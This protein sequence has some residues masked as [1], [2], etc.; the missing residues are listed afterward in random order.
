[1]PDFSLEIQHGGVVVGVDE[2]GR[3]PLAG[4]VYACAVY[5][6][7]ENFSEIGINDSKKM[8]QKKRESICENLLN[9]PHVFWALGQAGV[10]EI[11]TYNI[12]QATFMAMQRAVSEL[13]VS[14]DLVLVDGNCAPN[15]SHKTITVI[16]GDNISTSI[17]AAS[18]IAKVHRDKLM[19]DLALEYPH[20]GWEQNSGYGTKKHKDAISTYGISPMHRKTWC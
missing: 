8:T 3:G 10:D 4:P 6:E 5:I 17:A 11:D 18:I 14:P 12:R 15:W 1:M 16:K 13:Q 20:Y 19:S 9:S 7:R 2:V